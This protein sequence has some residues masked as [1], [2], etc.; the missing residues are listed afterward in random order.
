MK[1]LYITPY[2]PWPLNSGG[3]Q[4]FFM[5]A[6]YI[7]RHHQLS[8]LL[9]VNGHHEQAAVEELKKKWDNVSF[10]VFDEQSVK[11][12]V[13]G[14]QA[15]LSSRDRFLYRWYDSLSR[16]LHRKMRRIIRKV[17]FVKS[18]ST[19]FND[20]A[21]MDQSYCDYVYEVSR[22]GFDVV[23]VEFYEY[24]YLAYLLPHDLKKVF[25]HHELRFVR[26]EIEMSLF[27]EKLTTENF[28]YEQQKAYEI[29]ALNVYDIIVTLTEVDKEIL[30]Q[31]IPA[32]KICV[33]PA[34][35]NSV[36]MH[37]LSYTPADELVFVGSNAHFP[38][39]DA[40]V[41][42]VREI[43]P[44]LRRKC[45]CVPRLNVVGNWDRKMI[46]FLNVNETEVRFVGFVEN[47]Q[48]FINGKVSVVP[49]RIGSGM[50]M[51]I[52]DSVS[53]GSPLVTTSK[54]CEGLPMNH[55]KNCLIGDTAET[56]AD[57]I[58]QMMHDKKQQESLAVEAQQMGKDFLDEKTLLQKRLAVYE[59]FSNSLNS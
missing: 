28:L 9:K 44:V 53:A 55:G 40:V 11:G 56:F 37:H 19:L 10:Y 1:L 42:Y 57:A 30:S 13:K 45:Q 51:K 6:D 47:L 15:A 33:S 41:W 58:V 23:Q 36:G 54:G 14:V 17:D 32:K 48:E 3:N 26:N 38:N 29:T 5:M 49:I 21:D 59:S 52:L 4:A 35:T 22:I 25:I 2:I 20:A 12:Q 39:A 18:H 31:Y 24:L 8:L 46:K 43:L 7:R 34:I 27:K 50:R 16:S